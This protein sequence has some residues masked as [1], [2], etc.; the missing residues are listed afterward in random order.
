M[1][2]VDLEQAARY[3]G[4]DS[5]AAGEGFRLVVEAAN[6]R[7]EQFCGRKFDKQLHTE[8][9]DI[10]HG[11][12]DTLWVLNPPI[13]SVTS[14]TDDADTEVYTGRG[15]RAISLTADVE[16]YDDYLRLT[17][18]ESAFSKGQKSVK[19]VYMGGYE[20]QDLPADL[21]LAGWLLVAAYWE[22]PEPIMR[23]AQNLDGAQISWRD[24]DP[25]NPDLP[26]QV[27]NTLRRYARI[28]L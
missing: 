16:V 28:V 26:T 17:N 19:V 15:N 1:P 5:E 10:L 22:G 6:Q 27:A 23:S 24:P 4:I 9:H 20:A 11:G 7:I 14:L 25:Q 13:I 12:T 21:K 8:W 18:T 2:V 3:L